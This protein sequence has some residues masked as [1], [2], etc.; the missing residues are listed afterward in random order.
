MNTLQWQ[1]AREVKPETGFSTGT[2]A[3]QPV[4]KGIN[5][6]TLRPERGVKLPDWTPGTHIDLLLDNGMVRQYSLCGAQ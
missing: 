5:H 2:E 4:S 3:C 6:L 1:S